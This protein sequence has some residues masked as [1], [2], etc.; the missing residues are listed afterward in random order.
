MKTHI[1]IAEEKDI[2]RITQLFYETIT[3][4]NRKD[5]LEEQIKV[6]ADNAKNLKMW[7][8]AI[9]EQYFLVSE[10][11]FTIYGFASLDKNRGVDFMY[12]HQYF[13]GK[14]VATQLLSAIESKAIELGFTEIWTDSSIT[15]KPFFMK[16]GFVIKEIYTKKVSGID[17][18][19]TILSKIII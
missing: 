8:D 7:T 11:D 2:K 10:I 18:E 13:Q 1:R 3:S 14:G 15:A 17:F 9:K 5:Y 6:W 19:N 12:I 4:V 16:K